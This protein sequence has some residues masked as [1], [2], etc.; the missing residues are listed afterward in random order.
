MQVPHC[1]AAYACS[2]TVYA[3]AHRIDVVWLEEPPFQWAILIATLLFCG[4]LIPVGTWYA[5]RKALRVIDADQRRIRRVYL[6]RFI[7]IELG[8]F[9]AF[10]SAS[11]NPAT[12][13]TGTGYWLS[14][15]A[16]IVSIILGMTLL[17]AS[18]WMEWR[19]QRRGHWRLRR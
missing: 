11:V 10:L 14:V 1:A 7:G 2:Y 9:P 6:L 8:A 12:I 13:T 16:A 15:K 5:Y 17:F 18:V 19:A 3:L 4:L